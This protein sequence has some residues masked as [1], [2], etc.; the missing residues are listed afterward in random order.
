MPTTPSAKRALRTSL[1]RR[2]INLKIKALY[3][4]AVKIARLNPIPESLQKTYSQL[5]RA[6]KKKVIHPR[7]AARLKSRLSR[8]LSLKK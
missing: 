5:D 8:G 4:G 7:K 2:R 6:A 3:K 1:R